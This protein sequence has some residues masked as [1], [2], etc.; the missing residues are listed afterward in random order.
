MELDALA[1]VPD[2]WQ[3]RASASKVMQERDQ[4]QN[5]IDRWTE[6]EKQIKDLR[7]L[8][9]LLAAGDASLRKEI[10]QKATSLAQELEQ[11]ENLLFLAGPY[12]GQPCYLFIH[13]GAGGVDAKDWAGMLLRMYLRYCEQ[14]GFKVRIIDQSDDEVAGINS[15]LLYITGPWAY[16]LLKQE[17]GV[18]RLIRLSPFSAKSLRHTSFAAVDVYPELPEEEELELEEKDLRIDTY[19]STGAGGQHVNVTESAV[20]ITHL[21]TGIVVT[22][23]NERSQHQNKEQAMKVLQSRLLAHK[24]KE[25]K[26]E[27]AATKGAEKEIGF[28]SQIRTYTLH[29]YQLVKDHRS[30]LETGNVEAVLNGDLT[31][32]IEASLRGEKIK[33]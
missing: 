30:N 19:R 22:C 14:T 9:D 28:G 32:F 11:A 26:A 24:E 33:K 5:V 7:E 29:P 4:L 10:E 16:G 17:V 8:F 21:P 31:E 18:H 12:D 3:D 1:A 2:F 23:Q 27:L 15:A 25:R 13:A 20:R 6:L